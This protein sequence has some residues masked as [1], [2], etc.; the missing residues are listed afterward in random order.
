MCFTFLMFLHAGCVYLLSV[1][2]CHMFSCADLSNVF[3]CLL[4]FFSL[5]RCIHLFGV[6]T[7][8]ICWLVWCIHLSDV[9]ICSLVGCVHLSDVLTCLFTC[10]NVPLSKEFSCQICSL[11][12]YVRLLE[13]FTLWTHSDV[14]C[15]N[16]LY[17]FSWLTFFGICSVTHLTIV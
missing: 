8:Q 11:I 7:C 16:F 3:A 15:V 6:F 10:Q 14:F 1:F 9:F 5:V 17:V 2:T 4:L 13:V 12:Y